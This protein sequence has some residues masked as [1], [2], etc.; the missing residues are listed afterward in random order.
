MIVI[1]NLQVR[2]YFFDLICFH[3]RK[4]GS[5]RKP[6][7]WTGRRKKHQKCLFVKSPSKIAWTILSCLKHLELNSKII[8]FEKFDV[9]EVDWLLIINILINKVSLCWNISH[10]TISELL[11]NI[12]NTR[13]QINLWPK[14]LKIINRRKLSYIHDSI[15]IMMELR[16]IRIKGVTKTI[17]DFFFASWSFCQNYLTRKSPLFKKNDR[18]LQNLAW[19]YRRSFS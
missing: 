8:Y 19:N 7:L 16:I 5:S 14:N 13:S 3:I 4:S 9:H 12:F 2:F 1:D 17:F 18:F 15:K 11:W 6:L 10:Q